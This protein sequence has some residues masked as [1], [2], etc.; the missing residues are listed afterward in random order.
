MGCAPFRLLGKTIDK[1]ENQT[2]KVF[3]KMIML[4]A[5]GLALAISFNAQTSPYLSISN[6]SPTTVQLNWTNQVGTSYRI[7]FSPNLA[8]PRSLWAS[9]EDAFSSDSNLVVSLSSANFPA[10]F[11]IVE[12]PTN[13][14]VQIFSLTNNQT[15]SGTVAVGVG[16]QIG[17][18]LQGVN[19]YLDGALIGYLNSGGIEFD[20]DT[21][22]FTN[23]LHTVYVSAVDTGN[24]TTPSTAIT[25]DFENPVRWLDADTLFQS[26]VPIDVQS[27]IFPGNWSVFVANTNG[28]IIRTFSG[29]TSDGNINTNWNGNDNNG[30]YA[31]DDAGYTVSVVVTSGGSGSS[32]MMVT[33]GLPASSGLFVLSARPNAYGVMEYQVE[34]PTPDPAV[35]YSNLVKNYLQMPV[36][37]RII[38]PPFWTLPIEPSAPTIKTLS[39]YDMLMLQ[40][41]TSGSG[42]T[43]QAA[44]ASA[45]Q[46]SGSGWTSTAI[47]REAPWNSAE[48]L[49]ARVPFSGI[50]NTTV[51]NYFLSLRDLIVAAEDVVHGDRGVYGNNTIYVLNN[52]GDLSTLTNNLASAYPNARGLYFYGHGTSTGDGFGLS[53]SVI[54]AKDLG[55]LLGNSYQPYR[56]GQTLSI[57]THKP[58][59]FVFLDGCDTGLG[60]LPEA[61]GIPKISSDVSFND[62][63]KHKRAFMGWGGIVSFQF[64]TPQFNWTQSF[65][66]SWLQDTHNYTWTLQQAVNDA[67]RANP[68]VTTSLPMMI[69]GSQSLT[70]SN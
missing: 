68:G 42:S 24:N 9:L 70:W 69:Y 46:S 14:G 13:G 21:T 54:W 47:W 29:T 23:G 8:T 51:Q 37:E 67:N 59:D 28:T 56:K 2:M 6:N 35:T 61:F 62:Y 58:F 4:G 36:N 19:L 60:S 20:L 63:H 57:I 65:W 48:I 11:Y 12:I 5:L 43:T 31:P 40:I 41:R 49:L 50:F 27:D 3:R 66:N 10:G 32:S 30:V 33:S 16:A 1:R 18:Q 55:A 45:N 38:F 52:A 26:F 22:H 44:F 53:T 34:E 25:L 39:A 15:V 7:L 17:S 64:S